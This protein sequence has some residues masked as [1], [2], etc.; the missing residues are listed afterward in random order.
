MAGMTLA[1]DTAQWADLDGCR[2]RYELAG[3]G[4]GVVFVHGYGLDRRMWDGAFERLAASHTVVRYDCRGFGESEGALDDSY[5][6]GGDLL[7]L[8][9]HLDLGRVDLVGLSMG[10]QASMEVAVQ[11]PERVR[12]LVLPGPWLADYSFS[13][14]YRDMWT[15]LASQAQDYGVE[16]AKEMWRE[17]MLFNL[18]TRSP[19]AGARL[20][21]IMGR[22][23]GW[24]LAH[25]A[26]FPY[27]KVSERLAGVCAPTLV[28]LGELDLPDFKGVAQR[29][30]ERVP[31]AELVVLPE[32]GHVPN[33]EAPEVF[34]PLA[35]RFLAGS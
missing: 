4:P 32:V 26:H 30:A 18:E 21:E 28:V 25:V 14:D 23:T 3:S 2:L 17:S 19:T 10:S 29:I 16:V 13:K 34:E 6:H 5:T 20:R 31:G 9:D 1:D 15:L 24:H 12:R 27:A 35:E 22:W 11:W 33:L 7:A 8:L